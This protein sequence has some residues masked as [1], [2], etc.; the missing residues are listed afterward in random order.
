MI[1]RGGASF[2]AQNC[3]WLACP[4]TSYLFYDISLN[5][6]QAKTYMYVLKYMYQYTFLY[7]RVTSVVLYAVFSV[8]QV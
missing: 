4:A 2:S 1:R 8:I 6:S 3:F 5:E 7:I